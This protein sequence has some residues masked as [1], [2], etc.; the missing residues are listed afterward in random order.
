MPRGWS[1]LKAGHKPP[2]Q[3]PTKRYHIY[4]VGLQILLYNILVGV[5]YTTRKI[6]RYDTI[7]AC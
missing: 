6:L 2:Q 5:S 4:L 3:D 1:V 7:D